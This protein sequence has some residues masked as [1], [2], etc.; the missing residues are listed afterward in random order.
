MI[1]FIAFF[2]L[3][4]IFSCSTTISYAWCKEPVQ[5]TRETINDMADIWQFTFLHRVPKNK[6]DSF[7]KLLMETNQNTPAYAESITDAIGLLRTNDAFCLLYF[8]CMGRW[9][10]KDM[11]PFDKQSDLVARYGHKALNKY[12]LNYNVNESLPV[13]AFNEEVMRLC[14]LKNPVC[15]YCPQFPAEITLEEMKK[16]KT[17]KYDEQVIR[18]IRNN[19]DKT[20]GKLPRRE[21]DLGQAIKR[22]AMQL[23]FVEDC[24]WDVCGGKIEIYPEPFVFSVAMVIDGKRVERCYHIIGAKRSKIAGKVVYDEDQLEY[25]RCDFCPGFLAKARANCGGG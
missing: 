24:F 10:I 23:H 17:K 20:Q 12:F 14:A 9:I 6:L 1:R 2:C 25:F 13:R 22:Q 3:L 5:V 21:S 8:C 4:F 19:S 7:V 16:I 11:A 15:Y 18:I